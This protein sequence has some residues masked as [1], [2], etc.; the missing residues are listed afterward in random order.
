VRAAKDF[1]FFAAAQTAVLSAAKPEDIGFAGGDPI[2]PSDV[3]AAS[4]GFSRPH[5]FPQS[6][7]RCAFALGSVGLRESPFD[8]TARCALS[9]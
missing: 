2:P 8:C 4:R 1:V 7:F 9:R 5:H 6:Q 3:A